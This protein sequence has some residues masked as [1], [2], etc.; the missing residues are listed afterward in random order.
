MYLACTDL[1]LM[2]SGPGKD[3]PGQLIKQ[4][5]KT[6]QANAAHNQ[7]MTAKETPTS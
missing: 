5:R 7:N 4:L 6:K 3:S 1:Y 2:S